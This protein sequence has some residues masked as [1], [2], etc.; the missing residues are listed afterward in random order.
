[1]R[2]LAGMLLA[3]AAALAMA[4]CGQEK[5][6]EPPPVELGPDTAKAAPA[7]PTIMADASAGD[8]GVT[9]FYDPAGPAP[10]KP[11]TMIRTETQPP[12]TSL[13]S[14]G[15]GIRILY[16]STDGL[17]GKTPIAVSGSLFLPKG[18]APAS[19]WPL[20]AWAHGTVGVADKCAPSFNKRSERDTIYL[21]HWLDQGYAVVASDYQGLGTP[22]GHPYLATKPEAFSVLD[23][24]R[25]VQGVA[26][27]HIGKPVVLVGQS[28]GG[29]GAFA[30]A[31]EA[32]TY[33]PEI[34]IRGTVATGTPY[35]TATAAPVVRDPNAVEGVFAYTLFILHL[36]HQ[37]DKSFDP[38]AIMTEA[39]KPVFALTRTGCLG[40]V[41]KAIVAA[42]LSQAKA[43]TTDPTATTSKYYP[44]MAYSTLKVKGPVFMGTG[45]KDHDVPPPGQQR[46]FDDACAAGTV[47]ERHVYADLDHSGTVNGSLK[48]STP[49][50]KKAFAGE[51]IAGTCKKAG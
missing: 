6:K 4:G 2:L 15:Q 48:D 47:I 16:S 7:V 39:A 46:L 51:A 50:V 26:D 9:P 45:G 12:E 32:A 14:A 18:D 29:G 28:Q 22:G 38:D 20:I 49:F 19:G 3:G 5:K 10:A 31:G 13:A 30:T 40:D 11:G 43:F 25:A 42:N 27:Y 34:D 23:S 41:G 33:A 8:G 21:N 44:L 24:I 1:M 37:A 17:D 35:F 36:V